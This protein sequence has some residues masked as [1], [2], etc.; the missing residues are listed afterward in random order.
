MGRR[1][2]G[3]VV[4]LLAAIIF[5]IKPPIGYAQGGYVWPDIPGMRL[6]YA[7]MVKPI[8][9]LRNYDGTTDTQTPGYS[10]L[11]T[12]RYSSCGADTG[13]GTGGHSGVDIRAVCGT[14]VRAVGEGR[15]I[16][17]Y[18]SWAQDNN[19]QGFECANNQTAGGT[20]WGNKVV[21]LHN[22]V[23][24]DWTGN[25]G[26]LGG[27]TSHYTH[28][29]TVTGAARN[30]DGRTKV[31][32]GTVIG[33]VGSTGNSTGPHLHFQ[34]DRDIDIN[35]YWPGDVCS[36][37]NVV[38]VRNN[39]FSPMRFVQAHEVR[40]VSATGYYYSG[41]NFETYRGSRSDAKIDFEWFEGGPG[42][43]GVGADNFSV[44]WVGNIFVSS[45]GWYAFFATADDGV[46]VWVDGSLI[47][48]KWQDQP[49]YTYQAIRYLSVGA[50]EVRVEYYERGGG[51]TIKVAWKP[52]S[53]ILLSTGWEAD[54]LGYSDR[55]QYRANVA[56][57]Y[58]NES[59]PPECSRRQEIRYSGNWA[60]MIAGQDMSASQNSYCY[61]RVF[62]D[63]IEIR[64]GTMIAF[65]IY[66]DTSY[67]GNAT[68]TR[69]VSVDGA[70]WDGLTLRDFDNGAGWRITDQRGIRTHPA[71]RQDPINQ[72]YYVEVD[73][74]PMAGKVLDYIMF[75]YDDD[76]VSETGRYRAYVDNFYV[77]W[78]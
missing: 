11:W 75:A 61:Y 67:G 21:I 65:W 43:A 14:S 17:S 66:H 23:P 73:L 9:G 19:R 13:E 60:E 59:P 54:P 49:P 34:I 1:I 41:T 3:V 44:R 63:N 40:Q 64:E 10:V 29:Q 18:W 57:W 38:P 45:P 26:R 25:Y 69:H 47:I 56:G 48:D 50:H 7:G 5:T 16:Y 30:G 33:T 36:G 27:V 4:L 22:A 71:W 31:L 8:E 42:I 15:V 52:V 78:P 62:D 51:A 74:T 58:G 37:Q 20:G 6:H 76:Q 39:T 77:F 2:S 46:R 24:D 12:G 55:I 28:L 68:A 53:R 72:W 32:R 70:T 35:T